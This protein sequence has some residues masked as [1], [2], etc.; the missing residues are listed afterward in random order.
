MQNHVTLKIKK[1]IVFQSSI[2]NTYSLNLKVLIKIFNFSRTKN[3]KKYIQEQVIF[4][5]N[6]LISQTSP[7]HIASF[8]DQHIINYYKYH[9]K[10]KLHSQ[11]FYQCKIYQTINLYNPFYRNLPRL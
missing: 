4:Q 11:R 6:K 1:I 5:L 3:P 8:L 9:L 2:L 10:T 7:F